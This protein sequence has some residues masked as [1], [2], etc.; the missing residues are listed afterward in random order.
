MGSF[1]VNGT[2]AVRWPL[3]NLESAKKKCERLQERAL[4]LTTQVNKSSKKEQEI[5]TIRI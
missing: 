5:M 4:E 2:E 3:I 1:V